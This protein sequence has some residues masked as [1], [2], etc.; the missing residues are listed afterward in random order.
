MGRDVLTD[1]VGVL[2]GQAFLIRQQTKG[3]VLG[4]LNKCS[5]PLKA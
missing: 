5:K 3:G 1:M 2:L 4:T